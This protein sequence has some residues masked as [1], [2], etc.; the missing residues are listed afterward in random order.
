[1]SRA[2]A[3]KAGVSAAQAL[4]LALV[5][6]LYLHTSVLHA[7]VE[8]AARFHPRE[9]ERLVD[10]TPP[11]PPNISVS[12]IW[13]GEGHV[14]IGEFVRAPS[15]H[16]GSIDIEVNGASDDR[17][18]SDSLGYRLHYVDGAL[19]DDC[20]VPGEAYLPFVSLR[21]GRTYSLGWQDGKTWDQE[22]F[23]FRAYVTSMDWAGNESVPSDT[24]LIEHN[25]DTSSVKAIRTRAAR[26]SLAQGRPAEVDPVADAIFV[27]AIREYFDA[28]FKGE[29]EY[30]YNLLSPA[31]VTFTNADGSVAELRGRPSYEEFENSIKQ[32]AGARA[33]AIMRV[34]PFSAAEGEGADIVGVR[35]YSVSIEREAESEWDRYARVRVAAV[36]G[37]DGQ[38]RL[39]QSE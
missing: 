17:T 19:P 12:G 30:A 4:M 1:M 25:G 24:I 28:L 38:V 7:I 20:Q 16:H 13:R 9:S 32:W 6:P 35:K 33:D 37:T 31:A 15:E 39:F 8:V 11:L 3:W 26:Q 14:Q 22:A 34:A 36:R 29:A 5:V 23:S 18:P 27:D 21:W 10:R 2:I